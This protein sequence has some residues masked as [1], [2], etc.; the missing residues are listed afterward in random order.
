MSDQKL[1]VTMLGAGQMGAAIAAE[2]ASVGHEI[3]IT[4]SSRT[5]PENG[6]KRVHDWCPSA[7]V[8]WFATTEE[9]CVGADVVIE[10][11]AEDLELKRQ[12]FRKAQGVAPN[13]ILG[14][15][16]SSLQIGDIA[17]ALD[18]PSKLVGT[19]YLNPVAGFKVVELVAGDASD[20]VVFDRFDKLLQSFGKHPIK[21]KKDAPGFLI[22]RLQFG[23]LRECVSL[24]QKGIASAEDI[25]LLVKEGLAARWALAG[26]F[27]IV[28]MG[29]PAV[30][31]RVATQV[32]PHL[33]NETVPPETIALISLTPDEVA[34]NKARVRETLLAKK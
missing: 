16:T 19:H 23:F 1:Q 5:S 11:L 34:A 7:K 28:A 17:S 13:A 6:I 20:P 15:N 31:H 24:V 21:V 3:R 8:T 12:E 33:S 32:W 2:Y 30:F 22:N 10:S 26:P 14:S 4:T 9:A 27:T 18:D 25:D 29:G